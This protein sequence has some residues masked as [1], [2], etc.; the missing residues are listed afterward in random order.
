MN[1]TLRILVVIGLIYTTAHSQHQ[2]SDTHQVN[3]TALTKALTTELL[4]AKQEQRIALANAYWK[5]HKLAHPKKE[6]KK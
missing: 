6:Q 4:H 1:T 3:N 2:P 5:Q